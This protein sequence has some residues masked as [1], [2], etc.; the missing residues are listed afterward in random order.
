MPSTFRL[1]STASLISGEEGG[2]PIPAHVAPSSGLAVGERAA[3]WV[4]RVDIEVMH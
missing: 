4:G 1:T 3:V 2:F